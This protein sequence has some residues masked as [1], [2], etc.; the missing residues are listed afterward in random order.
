MGSSGGRRAPRRQLQTPPLPR[1]A[2]SAHCS[3][4]NRRTRPC[5]YSKSLSGTDRAGTRSRHRSQHR[6]NPHAQRRCVPPRI[7][8]HVLG[9][10]SFGQWPRP[11][12]VIAVRLLLL[13]RLSR[14]RNVPGGDVLERRVL[15]LELFDRCST[16]ECP[17][18]RIHTVND[19]LAWTASVTLNTGSVKPAFWGA[20]V[21]RRS[22][23]SSTRRP[24]RRTRS[25]GCES[26]RLKLCGR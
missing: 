8:L 18:L 23:P 26:P 4:A 6:Q 24:A 20:S 9:D 10:L 1:R 7:E 11:R 22:I 14:R 25:Q 15:F 5:G 17:K 19:P 21:A 13:L 12:W 2:R 3:L 16:S